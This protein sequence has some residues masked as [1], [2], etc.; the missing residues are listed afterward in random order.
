LEKIK[1]F[2]KRDSDI[3]RNVILLLFGLIFGICKLIFDHSLMSTFFG[4]LLIMGTIVLTVNIIKE[5]KR[6]TK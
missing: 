1:T 5:F 6:L 3:L 2:L 4:L